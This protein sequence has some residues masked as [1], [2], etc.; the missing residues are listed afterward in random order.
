MTTAIEAKKDKGLK[1]VLAGSAFGN[2][3]E[4]FDY[5]SYGYLATIIATVFFAPGNETVALLNTFAV[6]ALSF[7]IRPVGGLVWGRY[8]DRIGRKKCL[9]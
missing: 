1:Q 2:M 5:A 7:L 3:I 4:W 8:G 6:F 9:F